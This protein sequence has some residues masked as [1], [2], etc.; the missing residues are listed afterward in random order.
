MPKISRPPYF[1][2]FSQ[3][4]SVD[5]F[6]TPEGGGGVKDLCNGWSK[7]FFLENEVFLNFYFRNGAK[8]SPN[9]D[10]LGPVELIGGPNR[11]TRLTYHHIW[12]E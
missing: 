8:K 3:Q 10:T 9:G 1:R 6:T 2:L 5:E 12:N 4:R 7:S 11:V